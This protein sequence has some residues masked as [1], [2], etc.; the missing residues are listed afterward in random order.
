M[1]KK[2]IIVRGKEYKFK[3]TYRFFAIV[4]ISEVCMFNTW[5][6]L[7]FLI[8][9]YDSDDDCL[10]QNASFLNEKGVFFTLKLCNSVDDIWLIHITFKRQRNEQNRK[11]VLDLK[12][13][14]KNAVRKH[15]I[16]FRYHFCSM[17]CADMC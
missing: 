1:R 15:L 16:W 9:K 5:Q 4:S 11:L 12:L 14:F 17:C 6:S 7:L 10:P 2:L 8:L 3:I 13:A